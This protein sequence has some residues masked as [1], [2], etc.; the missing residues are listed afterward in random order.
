V[1]RRYHVVQARLMPRTGGGFVLTA[2][3]GRCGSM[4]EDKDASNAF[5]GLGLG[6]NRIVSLDYEHSSVCAGGE[7]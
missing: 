2:R 7:S 4:F 1:S 5:V 3:C 6:V